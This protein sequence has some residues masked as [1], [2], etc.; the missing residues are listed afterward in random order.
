VSAQVDLRVRHTETVADCMFA[1]GITHR[2]RKVQREKAERTRF[3]K[4]TIENNT[5]GDIT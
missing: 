2:C 5:A 4:T 3:C 1:D